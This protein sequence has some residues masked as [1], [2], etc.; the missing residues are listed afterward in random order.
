MR[1]FLW[2]AAAHAADARRSASPTPRPPSVPTTEPTSE[3]PGGAGLGGNEGVD[4]AALRDITDDSGGRTE[5]VRHTR[6][7]DPATARIAD[8]LSRQYALGYPSPG[9]RDGK[10]H[11]IRVEV[12]SGRCACVP[13]ADIWRPRLRRSRFKTPQVPSRG[14]APRVVSPLAWF[15][16]RV[17]SALRRKTQNWFVASLFRLRQGS[18]GPP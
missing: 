15:R 17:A 16:P 5:V 1:P 8:E 10:W 13:G 18:G 14:F 9:H 3:D 7:L 6:D 4:A 12:K 2:T 11:T